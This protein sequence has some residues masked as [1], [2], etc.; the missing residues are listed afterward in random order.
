MYTRA[1]MMEK[2]SKMSATNQMSMILR[3]DV[4]G[5]VWLVWVKKVAST[6]SD[7]RDTMMRSWSTRTLQWI[8]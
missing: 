1:M 6:N 4:L 2:S 3:Y 8:S 5:I 7:V